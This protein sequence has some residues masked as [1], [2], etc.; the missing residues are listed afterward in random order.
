MERKIYIVRHGETDMNRRECLQGHIDCEL[1]DK[2]IREAQASKEL[3]K[4]AGIEFGRV[5]SSPL[6]RAVQTAKII[7][8]RD[9]MTPEPLIIEMHFGDYEGRPYKEI[10][11]KMWAFIHDPENTAPPEGVEAISEL[12]GRTGEFIRRLLSE[13]D[14]ENVLIVTHGIA[15]RSILWNLYDEG[16]RASVWSMPI[17]NCIVYELT[18]ENGK[19]TNIRRAEELSKKSSTDTS[20]A[21]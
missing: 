15:L 12:T 7:S 13:N 16:E 11:E 19:V 9:D 14:D 3:F 5:Y 21:F 2:G 8:G 20:G 10:D 18:A 1:N 4:A 6:K 17:E